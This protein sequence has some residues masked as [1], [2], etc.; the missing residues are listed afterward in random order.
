ML[1]VTFQSPSGV[2]AY[3]RN[4][5]CSTHAHWGRQVRGAPVKGRELGW[6]CKLLVS[7]RGYP[8]LINTLENVFLSHRQ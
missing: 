3:K 2:L 8:L 4:K 5:P 7:M 6:N 1:P